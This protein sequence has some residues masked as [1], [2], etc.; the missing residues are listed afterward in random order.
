[1]PRIV[2]LSE[3]HHANTANA[4]S[5]PTPALPPQMASAQ[6]TTVEEVAADLKRSPFFMTSLEDDEA[7]DNVELAAMQALQYEGTRAEIAQGFRENGNEMARAK[8]WTDGKE[9]YTKALTALKVPRKEDEADETEREKE[10]EEASHYRLSLALSSLQKLPAALSACQLGLSHSPQNPSLLT[11][12]QKIQTTQA[13]QTALEQKRFERETRAKKEAEMLDKAL[14]LRMIRTRTTTQPPE[15]EDAAIRLIPDPLSPS[16]T[17]TF[18][19]ILLYPL[20]LQSDFIKSFGEEQTLLG[21]LEYLLPLPWD[22]N[23]EHTLEGTE[24]YME[25]VTGGLI[26]C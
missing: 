26:K 6:S 7:S 24:A 8:K 4:S 13:A 23:R 12:L 25:T 20:H 22:T 9:F 19:T 2:E 5:I 10:I 15:M 3:D 17:L 18:P 11:L 16:S 21:H 14:K 1:M